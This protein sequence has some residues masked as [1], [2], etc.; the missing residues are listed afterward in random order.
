MRWWIPTIERIDGN[1]YL[2]GLGGGWLGLPTPNTPIRI[3]T[4]EQL[5]EKKECFDITDKFHGWA[6]E[7]DWPGIKIAAFKYK[8]WMLKSQIRNWITTHNKGWYNSKEGKKKDPSVRSTD[9]CHRTSSEKQSKTI[10]IGISQRYGQSS[11]QSPRLTALL[12]LS[13]S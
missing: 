4:C 8:T 7:M 11:I 9:N 5:S 2:S 10:G 1:I 6:P 12:S 13:I 3:P